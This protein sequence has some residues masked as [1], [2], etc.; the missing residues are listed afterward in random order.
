[1]KN[2]PTEFLEL[3]ES[4]LY[5]YLPSV[6]GVSPNTIKSYKDT[7]RILLSYMHNEKHIDVG[8]IT[9]SDMDYQVLLGFLSWIETV[10]CCSITTRNQ[11]LSALSSFAGYAQNYNI[12]AALF[13]RDIKKIPSKKHSSKPRTFFTLEEIKQFLNLPKD[14]NV[15]EL[16]NKTMLSVMYASG[17]RAQEI[18][19]LRICNVRFNGDT[20]SMI[21]TGKGGKTRKVGIPIGCGILLKNYILKRGLSEKYEHHVFSSQTHEHMTVSCVE[22]I[23]KKYVSIAKKEYPGHFCEKNYTPHSM[24]HSTATHMLEAGVPIV[25]IKNFLGH[26]SIQSTQIYAEVTQSTVD[27]HIKAWN[28]KWGPKPNNIE[29]EPDLHSVVPDFLK[30]K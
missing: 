27:R 2:K 23:F 13:W 3:L 22:E 20:T 17:A 10:R 21:L 24:R 15:I 18:C 7:F 26:V 16:R 14:N 5:K 11:R 8:E 19:D 29:D 28:E 9:F 12:D 6:V 30:N 25:V 4:F 1:M